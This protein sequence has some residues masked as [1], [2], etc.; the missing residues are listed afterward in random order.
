MY[1]ASTTLASAGLFPAE[2]ASGADGAFRIPG[3]PP[4]FHALVAAGAEGRIE[5]CVL[6]RALDDRPPR[7]VLQRRFRSVVRVRDEAGRAVEGAAVY[8]FAGPRLV[9]DRL[10]L[11]QSEVLPLAAAEPGL[12]AR[13]DLPAGW[14]QVLVA[15]KGHRL[16]VEEDAAFGRDLPPVE[17]V[18]ERTPGVRGRVVWYETKEPVAG[19]RIRATPLKATRPGADPAAA[20]VWHRPVAGMDGPFA[21]TTMFSQRGQRA[22]YTICTSNQRRPHSQ[23]I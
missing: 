23:R 5:S 18:L 15:A 7:L 1:S 11:W 3:L 21:T 16:V 22:V 14:Y 17:V 8:A 9:A 6:W 20:Q 4:A 2:A 12:Y 10:A 19:V 13:D